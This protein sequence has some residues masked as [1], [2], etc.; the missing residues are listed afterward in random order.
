[1]S[2]TGIA[3]LVGTKEI[4]AIGCKIT[5]SLE[6]GTADGGGQVT[7]DPINGMDDPGVTIT[8]STDKNRTT[9]TSMETMGTASGLPTATTDRNVRGF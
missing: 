6:A 8:S 1:M 5:D 9:L 7:I 3:E 2:R 4:E